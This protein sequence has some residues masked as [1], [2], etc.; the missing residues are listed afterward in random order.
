M[1]ER[2]KNGDGEEQELLDYARRLQFSLHQLAMK[3]TER[4]DA[5]FE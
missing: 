1:S 3:S 4:T 2:Y 5:E